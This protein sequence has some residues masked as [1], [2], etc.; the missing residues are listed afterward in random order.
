M[1]NVVL[2]LLTTLL[3]AKLCCAAKSFSIPLRQHGLYLPL[4]RDE[5][6]IKV[7]SGKQLLRLLPDTSTTVWTT[8]ETLQWSGIVMR[9]AKGE[10]YTN[11]YHDQYSSTYKQVT[12]IKQFTLE[13]RYVKR[14]TYN[15]HLEFN[16]K[17]HWEES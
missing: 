10:T 14:G 8:S 1:K 4:S 15:L 17:L 5:A 7:G 11:G 12:T 9:D 6:A 2:I 3:C 16:W 13:V